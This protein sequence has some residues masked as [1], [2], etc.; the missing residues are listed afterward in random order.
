MGKKFGIHGLGKL[1]YFCSSKKENDLLEESPSQKESE[2]FFANEPPAKSSP[3]KNL[4][5]L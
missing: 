4:N 3:G 1:L 5:A 2:E